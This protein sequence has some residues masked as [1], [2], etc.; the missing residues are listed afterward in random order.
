MKRREIFL[1][2]VL[3]LFGI[4]YSFFKSED[5][6][7]FDAC[8]NDNRSLMDKNN[9]HDFPDQG[10]EFENIKQLVIH[11][12]AGHITIHKAE[13]NR[14]AVKAIRKIFHR[15][16]KKAAVIGKEIQ[17]TM[18]VSDETLYIKVHSSSGDF[19][20]RRARL[21][22]QISLPEVVELNLF[23]RYG[24][25]EMVNCGGKIR[26][27]GKYGDIS[28]K[29]IFSDL[30][31]IHGYGRIILDNING[32]T[33]VESRYSTLKIYN[34]HFVR[35][36]GRHVRTKIVGLKKGIW[37]RNSHEMI[38]IF[39]VK[40]NMSLDA[41]DCRIRLLNI[42]SEVVGLKNSYNDVSVENLWAERVDISLSHGDLN[43]KYFEIREKLDIRNQYSDIR[44][45]FSRSVLPFFDIGL[46][47]G[48]IVNKTLIALKA[49]NEKH[50]QIY[51]SEPGAPKIIIE[52]RYGNVVL[53]HTGK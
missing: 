24:N 29:N 28:A 51:T 19:P 8:S 27:D 3:I 53:C 42:D 33:E 13:N 41:K 39:D 22:F 17:I 40:G 6:N 1:V 35:I 12:P 30:N 25:L 20:Y 32:N 38:D 47:Y 5:F 15:N 46:S 49:L 37:L 26:I 52:N 48:K 43:L 10:L 45:E 21:F 11:N 7:F 31:I 44:L 36:E 16:P 9:P 50:K 18:R 23:N 14:I 4:M 2:V 34:S